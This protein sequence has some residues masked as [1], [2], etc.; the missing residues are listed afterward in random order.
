M[1][2]ICHEFVSLV[3]G[4]PELFKNA[5]ISV[6]VAHFSP[7]A[8]KRIARASDSVTYSCGR[9]SVFAREIIPL[10]AAISTARQIHVFAGSALTSV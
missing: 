4:F 2:P 1:M 10:S 9:K 7:R 3:K 5:S 8:E 6:C